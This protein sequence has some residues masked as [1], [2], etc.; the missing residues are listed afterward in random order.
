MTEQ[1]LQAAWERCEAAAAS[2]ACLAQCG[3]TLG[4]LNVMAS[5]RDVPTLL[6]EVERLRAIVREL[7]DS[8]TDFWDDPIVE[9][10]LVRKA[11]E[12]LS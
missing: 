3:A 12:A 4:G 7:A 1:E 9:K 2:L 5:A 8:E 10:S 6:A 11:K